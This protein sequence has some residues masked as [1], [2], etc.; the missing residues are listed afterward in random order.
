MSSGETPGIA[1][2]SF[3]AF[4]VAWDEY[5]LPRTLINSES[6][7]VSSLGLS[8][9]IGAYTTF[10]DQVMAAALL[11][12]LSALVIFIFPAALPG[13]GVDSRRSQGI[14]ASDRPPWSSSTN[15]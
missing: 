3:Y 1:A 8:S 4:I 9:F 12:G 14:R 10:W 11:V 15:F 13:L 6:K 7:W 2:T 5:L